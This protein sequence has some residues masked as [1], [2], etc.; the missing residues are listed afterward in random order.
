MRRR[1]LRWL[2]RTGIALGTVIVVVLALAGLYLAWDDLAPVHVNTPIP[3]FTVD[4]AGVATHVE[5]WAA[6]HPSGQPPVVLV[7]GFAESTYVFSR[8]AP[9][10]AED[11]DVYA[12]DV[13][14][15]GWSAH[16]GPYTLAADTDQLQGLL[17]AL[18]LTRPVVLGHSLGAAI[19]LSLALRDPGAVTGVVAANGDGT[20]YFGADR[21]Q[22][23]GG[24]SGLRTLLTLPPLGPAVV[25]AVVRHRDPIR[26]LVASQCGPGC[27]TDDRAI[28]RWRAPFLAPGGVGAFLAIARQPLIGLTDD[29]E[30]AI[31]VPTAV[32]SSSEDRS[33][34]HTQALA[35]AARLHTGLVA[36]LPGAR[37]L[38]LLGEPDEVAAALHPQLAALV[39]QATPRR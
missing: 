32:F 20:P 7:P 12:Y 22:A 35:T 17:A 1:V 27:P 2:R 28:D 3:G 38:A 4:A 5:H 24:G 11:R 34:D 14:G 26:R 18:H 25:T 33:F 10:L 36:E 29:Q 39:A 13:R 23:G 19:A 37:H 6:A 31:R 30:R 16:Q 8:L 9:R 15:Y 21:S